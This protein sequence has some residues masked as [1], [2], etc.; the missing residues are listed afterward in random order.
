[1][2]IPDPLQNIIS[3]RIKTSLK[4]AVDAFDFFFS[5]KFCKSL[6]FCFGL[7]WIFI[8]AHF[9]E[10]KPELLSFPPFAE[11]FLALDKEGLNLTFLEL[12]DIMSNAAEINAFPPLSDAR[13]KS[14]QISYTIFTK[15]WQ[16]SLHK[17]HDSLL[18]YKM[19]VSSELWGI[20]G[21]WAVVK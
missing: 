3:Y 7:I 20:I 8:K 5:I 10:L 21:P 12:P 4:E 18:N 6:A 2:G 19:K 14:W 1:M 13:W 9:P 15:E 11:R 17:I 16:N